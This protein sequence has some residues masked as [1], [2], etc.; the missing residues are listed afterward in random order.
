MDEVQVSA[1]LMSLPWLA[2]AIMPATRCRLLARRVGRASAGRLL[3]HEVD[4]H[5]LVRALAVLDVH[6]LAVTRLQLA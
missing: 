1:L 3:A 4:H 5:A 6:G 2:I